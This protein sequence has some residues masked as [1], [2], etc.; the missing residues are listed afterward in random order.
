MNVG[1]GLVDPRDN[2]PLIPA[3]AWK[4]FCRLAKL[5]RGHAY[6]LTV[7]MTGD[8]PVWTVQPLGKLENER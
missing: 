7:V 4:F 2:E 8:E 1:S 5:E 6:T 3:W